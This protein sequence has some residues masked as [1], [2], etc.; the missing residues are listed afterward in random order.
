MDSTNATQELVATLP[1]EIQKAIEFDRKQWAI[2]SVLEDPFYTELEESARFAGPGAPLKIERNTDTSKFTLPP[3][4]ALSRY[5]YQSRT[6]AG[7]PVPVSAYILWPYSPRKDPGTGDYQV[8]VWAHGTS[9]IAPN[10]APSH[11]KNLWHHYLAPF[12]L[13]LQGYVVISSDYAGLGV[14]MGY[15]GQAII[16]EWMSGPAQAN[17]ALYAF[18]AAR[19]AF[20]GFSRFVVMGHSQGGGTAWAIAQRCAIHP[21]QGYLGA[22]ACAPATRV[23]SEPG[24]LGTI[25][26]AG[27]TPAISHNLPEFK[28]PDIMTDDGLQRLQVAM[29]IGGSSAIS[30]ALLV[31]VDLLKPGWEENRFVKEYQETV[32]NGGKGIAGPLLVLHGLADPIL[33]ADATTEAVRLTLER[34]P[35]SR[36]HYVRMPGVS[37][38]PA[39]TASQRVWMDWI[40]DRFAGRE[41]EGSGVTE[42]LEPAVPLTAYQPELNWWLAGASNFYETP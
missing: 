37:H 5:V 19:Q 4:T 18:E 7:K 2:G 34:F 42:D 17:D 3:A 6:L 28:A 1:E 25:I 12:Q 26:V 24:Q 36:I 29:A 8:V 20:T 23:L 41:M 40:A 22:V 32:A 30:I 21:V 35:E 27:M 10:C 31:G 11:M 38:N 9:G 33:N 15:D 16:H 39:T 14:A 13:V